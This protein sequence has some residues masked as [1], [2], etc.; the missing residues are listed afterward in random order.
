MRSALIKERAK[1]RTGKLI[2]SFISKKN[3][4]RSKAKR[5]SVHVVGYANKKKG[6][7]KLPFYFTYNFLFGSLRLVV[8]YS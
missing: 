5:K 7:D 2:V 6:S 4:T 3:V 1:K 8:P